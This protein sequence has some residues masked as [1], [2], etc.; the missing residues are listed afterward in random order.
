MI[1]LREVTTSRD[2][3]HPREEMQDTRQ[4][5]SSMMDEKVE[6]I[7]QQVERIQQQLDTFLIIPRQ[8]VLPHPQE[9]ALSLRED[10]APPVALSAYH[11]ANTSG[12]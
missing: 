10:N 1:E 12:K 5:Y 9:D 8:N 6:R 2:I 4:Q 7:Q 3:E 11:V